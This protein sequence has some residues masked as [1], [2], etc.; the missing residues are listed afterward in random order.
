MDTDITF[1]LCSI[2]K[3]EEKNLETFLERHKGFFDEMIMVDT[4][5]TD[6]S[7]EITAAYGV[8]YH[9]FE[10]IKDFAAARNYSLSKATNPYIIILDIDEHLLEED[11]IRLKETIKATD[12]DVYSLRQINLIDS[13]EDMN[14]KSVDTLPAQFHSIAKGYITSPL[15]RVF[16]NFKGISFHGIIHELV[17]ESVTRLKLS[18]K[19]TDIP[20][21]HYGWIDDGRTD[22]EKLQK[23]IAYRELIE[24]AWKLDPSP[25]MAFYYVKTLEEPKEKIRLAYKLTKQY[26]D[27][28]QFW[29]ILAGE[30]AFLGQWARA[31]AYAEK[32]L[33]HHPVNASLAAVRVRCLNETAQPQEALE[34]AEKLLK[35]DAWNPVY[36]FEKFRALIMLN[37]RK[38]A[39]QL[40][41]NFPPNFP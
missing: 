20:F 35:D 15:F 7:N 6:R 40:V 9:F 21:Y 12:R 27:V 38:E 32:G 13:R 39:Q 29:E 37:R 22:E 28:K 2:Y 26:P 4:G 30:S 25:K 41:K 36:W 31:L 3:N 19:V 34:I 5:S 1:S 24:K 16:R 8:P 18:S 17:G 33:V 14:W 23:K 10:W 11:F